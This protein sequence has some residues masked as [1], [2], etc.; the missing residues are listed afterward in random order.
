M[1]RVIVIAVL[2]LFISLATTV[3]KADIKQEVIARC[4]S[5][6]GE[7][8]SALVKA[9]VDQDLKALVALNKYPKRYDSIVGRCMNSMQEYGYALVKACADQDIKAEKELADY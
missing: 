3:A 8:G 7:Y 2:S 6:M 4:R 9:C 5:Q 1:I